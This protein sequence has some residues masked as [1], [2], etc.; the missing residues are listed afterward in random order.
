LLLLDTDV[1]GNPPAL[2]SITDRLYP[3]DPR[4]RLSQEIV[5]GIGGVRA[6]RGAGYDPMLFHLNEGHSFLANLELVREAVGNGLPLASARE[7]VRERCVFTTHTPVAAGSDYFDEDLVRDLLG[8]FLGGLGVKIDEYM[9]TGRIHPGDRGERLCTTFVALRSSAASVGVSRLHGAVSRRLWKDAWPGVEEGRVPIGSVTNGVHM[10]TWVA[11][12]IADLLREHVDGR[13]WDLEPDD[14]RWQGVGLIPDRVLWEAHSRLRRALVHRAIAAEGD[15]SL[16]DPDKLTIGF[17]R[18]FAQYKRAN[19]LLTDLD[20]LVRI[21]GR[22]GF[23]VQVV[24]SGKA[25]PND[26]Q[27]KELLSEIV[28]FAQ[29]EPRVAFIADYNLEVARALVQGADVWLN[30]PRRLLEASGTS[31]MKA[32]ANGA[33]NLS[34]SD[35]WWDEGRRSDSGW[36]IESHVT[37]DNPE[38]DDAAE[39]DALYRLLESRIVPLFYDRDPNGLPSGWLAMMRASIRHVA[40]RF[41]ARRMVLDYRANCYL[42]AARRV[43]ERGDLLLFGAGISGA[44]SLASP[45]SED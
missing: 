19:L 7:H 42:P 43:L 3:A 40:S 6:L 9:D 8:P 5:L 33:L 26:G 1:E 4:P 21:L 41:S 13:W 29:I 31:G 16:F 22:P 35:G 14:R 39:A 25:H 17:G 18:R 11:G 20:R 15:N 27:G 28:R 36:T 34:V 2:R 12:E 45:P 10:P 30:N 44:G 23:E 24:F 37:P 32:G 38:A